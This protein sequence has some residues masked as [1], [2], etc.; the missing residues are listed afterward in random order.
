MRAGRGAA[1]AAGS[2][3]G[4]LKQTP[5][6]DTLADNML[7]DMLIRNR[8]ITV[9]KAEHGQSV[10]GDTAHR[11]QALDDVGGRVILKW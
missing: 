7:F 4:R 1:A 2:L 5:V 6:D 8:T 10:R 11:R 3:L 9:W